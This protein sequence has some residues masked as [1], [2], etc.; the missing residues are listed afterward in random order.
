MEKHKGFHNKRATMAYIV[1]LNDLMNWQLDKQLT[2]SVEFQRWYQLNHLLMT[3]YAKTYKAIIT[4]QNVSISY[5]GDLKMWRYSKLGLLSF[6]L[7]RR[8]MYILKWNLSTQLQALSMTFIKL[9]IKN[10]HQYYQNEIIDRTSFF[11]SRRI[12]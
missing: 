2:T 11:I 10:D 7:S 12:C 5:S 8:I 6:Y 9:L 3:Q 4:A 1:H